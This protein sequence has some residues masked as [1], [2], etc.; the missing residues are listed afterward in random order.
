MSGADDG[1]AFGRRLMR[2]SLRATLA[3]SLCGAPYASLVLVAADLDASPLLLLSD[4]AQHSRNLAFDP[5]LSLLFDGT[6][7]MADPLAGPRLTLLGQAEPIDDRCRLARFLARHPTSETYAGFADFRLYRVIVERGHLVAGFGRIMWLGAADLLFSPPAD[8]LAV[9]EA[10]IV[11]HMNDDHADAVALYAT[12]L[13]GRV[14]QGWR[15][16]GIDP[17]GIDLRRSNEIARLDFPA[18]ALSP[19]AARDALVELA[20]RARQ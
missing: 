17:E 2:G 11:R 10:A 5:R 6:A 3:T 4:L 16:I 12:R 19:E 13:L 18:P 14:G 15:M 20:A 8:G 9:A 1:A 7:G